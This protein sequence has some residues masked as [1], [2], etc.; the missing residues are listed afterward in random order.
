MLIFCDESG[1]PGL[2]TKSGASRYFAVGMLYC[3]DGKAAARLAEAQDKM[4]IS[5]RWAGE[6]KWSKMPLDVRMDYMSGMEPLLL[7]HR[8]AIWDKQSGLLLL[9]YRPEVE[10]MRSCYESFDFQV[11]AVRMV[12]DGE[13]DSH[14][15]SEIRAALAV[16]EVRMERSHACPQLQM[17]DMLVGF[18]AYAWRVGWRN[19][20]KGLHHLEANLRWC[21]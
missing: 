4:R 8:V 9:R 18:H 12:I 17:A 2:S 6:F 3:P 14:R 20:P 7:S 19:V 10:V 15:S 1:D 21:R 16:R 11:P 5:L 13:R